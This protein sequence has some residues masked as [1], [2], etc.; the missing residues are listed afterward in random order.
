LPP[1]PLAKY[2]CS[3]NAW[4]LDIVRRIDAIFAIEQ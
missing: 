2:S 1:D 3:W 4:L